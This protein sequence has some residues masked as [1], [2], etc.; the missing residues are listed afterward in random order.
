[1]QWCV[2][3]TQFACWKGLGIS[4][5]L[6]C[7]PYIASALARGLKARIVQIVREASIVIFFVRV[8][9]SVLS[10]LTQFR[11]NQ[12]QHAI[13][14]GRQSKLV[15]LVTGVLQGGVLVTLLFLLYTL[16]L[17]SILENNSLLYQ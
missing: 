12:S 15:N 3:T 13:V 7:V 14:D 8:E 5:A 10:I 11:S 2:P 16:E 17:L 9:G 1:M 6:L 4:N